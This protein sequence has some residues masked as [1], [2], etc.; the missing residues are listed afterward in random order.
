[1]YMITCTDLPEIQAVENKRSLL[2]S[3][4]VVTQKHLVQLVPAFP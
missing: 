1:M 2:N 3:T 4:L